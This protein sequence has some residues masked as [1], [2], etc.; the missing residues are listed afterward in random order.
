MN[1][2]S[3][4]KELCKVVEPEE[5]KKSIKRN[6]ESKYRL[7]SLRGRVFTENKYFQDQSTTTTVE[8]QT[9][10]VGG[11]DVVKR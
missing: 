9:S 4:L 2:V 8:K 6:N 10:I 3:E 7:L 1:V 5:E 11:S